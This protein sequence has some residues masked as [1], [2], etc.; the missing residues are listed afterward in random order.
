[1]GGLERQNISVSYRWA[2]ILVCQSSKFH[3]SAVRLLTGATNDVHREGVGKA[4]VISTG[5]NASGGG[6]TP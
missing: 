4:R 2:E 3:A 5:E 1:M 6:G